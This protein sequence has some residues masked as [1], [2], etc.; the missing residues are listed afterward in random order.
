MPE[1]K[2]AEFFANDFQALAAA[3]GDRPSLEDTLPKMTM[4]CLLYIGE[5]DGSFSQVQA[6]VQHMPNVSLV[7]FPGLNHPE[8][9]Y[10][11]D[12][13]L[14]HVMKFLQAEHEVALC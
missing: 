11:A 7:S 13:V 5:A 1:E 8:A 2:Q 10:R 12:V 6:C 3:Q 4:P 14:P 9:F